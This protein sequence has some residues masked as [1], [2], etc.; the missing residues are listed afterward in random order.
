MTY[1][2]QMRYAAHVVAM[3]GVFFAL[4]F[5]AS[6]SF[7]SNVGMVRVLCEVEGERKRGWEKHRVG[8]HCEI[9]L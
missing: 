3:M 8:F 5:I 4:G 9:N 1:K 2:E 7:T 6:A